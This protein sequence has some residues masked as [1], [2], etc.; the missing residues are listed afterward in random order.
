MTQQTPIGDNLLPVGLNPVLPDSR[1]FAASDAPA[2][3]KSASDRRTNHFNLIRVFA[4]MGVLFSHSFALT[5]H[6]EF[7]IGGKTVGFLCVAVF[8]SISG[9][10]I[11]KSWLRFSSSTS[12][13]R[14]RF[15][16][17]YPGLWLAVAVTALVVGPLATTLPT[18]EYFLNFRFLTYLAGNGSL[19]HVVHRLPGVFE[20]SV[21][22]SANGSLWTLPYE[23][24]CYAVILAFGVLSKN[25]PKRFVFLVVAMLAVLLGVAFAA[26]SPPNEGAIQMPLFVVRLAEL[27]PYFFVGSLVAHSPARVRKLAPALVL[28][29]ICAVASGNPQALSLVFPATLAPLVVTLAYWPN[30]LLARYNR[31]G[32]YS[33]GIYL[34]AF[35]VQQ[36]VALHLKDCR[37]W[38]NILYSLPL[39]LGLAFVSWHLLESRALKFVRQSQCPRPGL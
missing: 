30:S 26:S 15:L 6:P 23:I 28:G 21:N 25:H 20:E 13:A 9:F 24:I 10:L 31:F 37:P 12:F 32:D 36:M 35:P 39:V 2:Q 7:L 34:Y 3:S 1:P 8:F 14:N 29:L 17:I 18:R 5:G 4:A 38:Q 16:R 33:Y 27:L 11:T 22:H 19:L